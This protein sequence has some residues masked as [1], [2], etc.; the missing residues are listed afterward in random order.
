MNRLGPKRRIRM[1]LEQVRKEISDNASRGGPFS[2]ALSGE[3]YAG[4]YYDA[5]CDIEILLN[6][7]VPNRR[8]YWKVRAMIKEAEVL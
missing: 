7:N 1:A 8:D 4:G 6:G 3:G 5:L 2:S